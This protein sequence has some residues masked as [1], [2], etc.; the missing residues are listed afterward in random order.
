MHRPKH[1]G[2]KGA[3]RTRLDPGLLSGL[4]VN[5]GLIYLGQP[6]ST[7]TALRNKVSCREFISCCNSVAALPAWANCNGHVAKTSVS[8]SQPH[9]PTPSA[10]CTAPAA[11][12]VGV[13]KPQAFHVSREKL[14]HGMPQV[15]PLLPALFLPR[16]PCLQAASS[17]G[18]YA[19]AGGSVR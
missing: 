7:M 14:P 8:P 4:L 10:L 18:N 17:R 6:F 12:V 19:H 2:T 9:P 5:G 16:A 13:V 11:R 3:H 15:S 1:R